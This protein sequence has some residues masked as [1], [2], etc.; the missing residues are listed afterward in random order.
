MD[1][2]IFI[3]C[4]FGGFPWKKSHLYQNEAPIYQLDKIRTP[5]HIITGENDVRVP[6]SQSYMFERALYY[7]DIPVKLLVFPNEGHSL[8]NNPWH[9]KIKV[10][11]ELKW[12]QKYG[13]QSLSNTDISNMNEKL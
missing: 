4:L 1:I 3:D 7:Q 10:R 6:A 2:P 8:N 9:G 5:T 13:N 12:L 11:E